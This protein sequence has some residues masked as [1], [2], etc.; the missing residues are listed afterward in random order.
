MTTKIIDALAK[1]VIATIAVLGYPGI[2]LLMLVESCGVPMPSEIIMPFSG[3]LVAEGRMNLWLVSLMGALGNVAGSLLAYW[4][5]AKGGRPLIERY[6]RYVLISKHDLNTADR[7]FA[8]YGEATAFFSRLMPIVRTY[9]SFPAGVARMNVWRFSLYTFLGALPWSAALAYAGVRMG[10]HW[11]MIRE[12][13]HR[14]D[15]AVGLLIVAG[16]AWYVWR[17]VK[18]AR[19]GDE[20]AASAD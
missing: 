10:E 18:H 7:W 20:P 6:G 15:L 12:K 16:L 13:L 17:H 8:K 9:I 11:E 4:I 3:F 14:F 19:E 1:I 5:G 2:F